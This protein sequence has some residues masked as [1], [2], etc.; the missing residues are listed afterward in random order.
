M[1]SLGKQVGKVVKATRDLPQ[2]RPDFKA[3]ATKPPKKGKWTAA[4]YVLSGGTQASEAVK[5]PGNYIQRRID[6]VTYAVRKDLVPR[7][8]RG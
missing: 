1:P 7:G 8:E 6:G 5:V 3:A 2:L 4:S